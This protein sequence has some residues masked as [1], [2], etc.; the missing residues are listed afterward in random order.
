MQT[1]I[2]G[3]PP[4]VNLCAIGKFEGPGTP[5]VDGQALAT[6]EARDD[7]RSQ[8]VQQTPLDADVRAVGREVRAYNR[9]AATD[10]EQELSEKSARQQWQERYQ[11][12]QQD[13]ELAESALQDAQV[14]R[15]G[16]TVGNALGGAPFQDHNCNS[17]LFNENSLSKGMVAI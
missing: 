4:Q 15:E 1:F 9:A 5:L 11:K 17:S 6:I 8:A 12:A 7:D 16:D 2:R 14:I 3:I 10:R 13:V